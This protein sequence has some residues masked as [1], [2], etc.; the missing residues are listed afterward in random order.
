VS[1][2]REWAATA[3]AAIVVATSLVARVAI[4]DRYYPGWDIVF[5]TQGTFV[6]T[7]KSVREALALVVD[8]TAFGSLSVPRNSLLCALLPG[9][10]GRLWPWEYWGHL[11]TLLLVVAT[12]ALVATAMTLPARRWW[13]VLLAWGASPAL[14]SF[15][16][17]GFPWATAFLP[18]ALALVAVLHPR[19]RRTWFLGPILCT[20]AVATAWQGY[21]LGKT[22]FVVFLAG[23]VLL[24][25]VPVL[26]RLLWLAT[27]A[28][29][30]HTVLVHPS[31]ATFAFMSTPIPSVW[32]VVE[33]TGRVMTDVF[34]V[35]HGLDLPFLLAAA[36]VALVALR[37]DRLFLATLLAVQLGLVVVLAMNSPGE[38]RPRRFLVVGYCAL[39]LVAAA[40]RGDARPRA[41]AA[42]VVL[43]VAGTVG[44]VG[45]LVA[46]ARGP[47]PAV[48]Y[49]LPYTYSQ[50]D[51]M[52]PRPPIDWAARMG[53][54][55][56]A[57][58]TVLVVYGR[59]AYDENATN[60]TNVLERIYLRVGHERFVR[61]V[62]VFGS[63]PC[64]Y[65]CLP[66][67]P[68][69]DI[70][71]ALADITPD[72]PI[73]PSSVHLYY[74]QDLFLTYEH[75]FETESATAFAAIR[76]RFA[77]REES[78][79]GPKLLHF[80][81]VPRPADATDGITITQPTGLLTHGTSG[82][83]EATAVTWSSL[84]FERYWVLDEPR[85]PRSSYVEPR[86]WGADPLR[87]ALRGTL[88]LARTGHYEV[89]LGA[90]ESAEVLLD[91]KPV[92]SKLGPD[93]RVA[94]VSLPLA[95]GT[96][97]LEVTATD[98]DGVAHLLVDI[99]REGD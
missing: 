54:E 46:F 74:S 53:D 97:A 98:Q 24:G 89:I 26:A 59:F 36:V 50:A 92:V 94:Q 57:G 40:F 7:T 81:L 8:P 19:V 67:R 70:D 75:T 4:R 91:G 71:R 27:G 56:L 20:A 1:A 34:F 13:I 12:L 63:L 45:N 6:A 61:S 42:I 17:A 52:V 14:L 18:H 90:D 68:L 79:L 55:V 51:Y 39:T 38:L 30:L 32:P 33:A 16:L 44:Q 15:S 60:P 31:A 10:L 28:F 69:S 93:F 76:R 11:V 2:R 73:L 48:D 37:R 43:L 62:L 80:R 88:A 47:R 99:Y 3:G 72:G 77:L 21:E 23:A 65:D 78:V 96:H 25:E 82:L 86:P 5:A 41:H 95:A 64:G 29:Q 87:V 83:G 22:A 9:Y 58:D 35:P 49:P 84:P 85:P 66:L